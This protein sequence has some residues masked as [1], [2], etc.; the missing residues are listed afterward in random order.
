MGYVL[1]DFEEAVM[2]SGAAT[3]ISSCVYLD[4]YCGDDA[5]GVEISI[6]FYN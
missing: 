6:L 4:L 3:D 2:C 5:E 1:V